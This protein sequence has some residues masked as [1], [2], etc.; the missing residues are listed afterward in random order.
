MLYGN[1]EQLTLLPYVNHIIK[2]LIIE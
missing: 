1:I 2:K